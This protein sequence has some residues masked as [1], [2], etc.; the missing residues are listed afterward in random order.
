MIFAQERLRYQGLS[1]SYA[2]IP[3]DTNGRM[4]PSLPAGSSLSLLESIK[5][6]RSPI[7]LDD[8]S[9]PY[10][11]YS[12]GLSVQMSALGFGLK[13]GQQQQLHHGLLPTPPSSTSPIWSSSFSPYQGGILSPELLAA[14]AAAGLSPLNPHYLSSY[15]MQPRLDHPQHA[16]GLNTG[17]LGNHA[18][19]GRTLPDGLAP[20]AQINSG[21]AQ[22]LPP[23][24]AAEYARR[25]AGAD[26]V[27]DTPPLETDLSRYLS[28][29]VRG[30][31]QS[32]MVPKPPPNTPYGSTKRLDSQAQ[33]SLLAVPSSPT[34]LHDAQ[35]LGLS[36]H[37]RSIPLNKLMQRRLSSVPEEDYAS[38]VENARTPAAH[39]RGH[40]RG[41]GDKSSGH[42]LHLYLSPSS[43]SNVNAASL[44]VLGDALGAH[45]G[46]DDARVKFPGASGR[47][48]GPAGRGEAQ[49][50]KE[51]HRRQGSSNANKDGGQR[52]DSG[53]GRGQKRG[54][55]GR[56]GR[57]GGFH[58]GNMTHG[59]ERVDGGMMVKS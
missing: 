52:G 45:Y 57:G 59:A 22:R 50:V 24:L 6:S 1:P 58:A 18:M 56:R 36:Q 28:S 27:A 20:P 37:P 29:P 44:D 53:R 33:K 43:R 55:R 46:I 51:V 30:V 31:S 19:P 14:A 11:L 5:S 4:N 54:G 12:R 49:A 39:T 35:S 10:G 21:G 8:L 23:R 47:T 42:G 38:G 15:G 17:V 16:L 40:A 25:R 48:S 32:P 13:N 2:N 3:S 26:P 41:A 34:S 7:V 9:S